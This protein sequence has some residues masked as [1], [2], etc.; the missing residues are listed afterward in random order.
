MDDLFISFYNFFFCESSLALS[1][2]SSQINYRDASINQLR[3]N[4]ARQNVA[5]QGE[6]AG[7]HPPKLRKETLKQHAIAF[8]IGNGKREPWFFL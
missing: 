2:R 4:S 6:H 3:A 8:F 5:I 7:M 1:L